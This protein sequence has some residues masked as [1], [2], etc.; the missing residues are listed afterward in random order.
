[1]TALDIFLSVSVATLM[2]GVELGDCVNGTDVSCV[3]GVAHFDAYRRHRIPSQAPQ[4][5]LPFLDQKSVFVARHPLSYSVNRLVLQHLLGYQ[6]YTGFVSL[7]LQDPALYDPAPLQSSDFPFVLSDV[8]I[9]ATSDWRFFHQAIYWDEETH[10]A[11]I[12]LLKTGSHL[13]LDPIEITRVLLDE[14]AR[15]KQQRGCLPTENTAQMDYSAYAEQYLS[16]D[17]QLQQVNAT[18][19]DATEDD[20]TSFCWIPVV[21]VAG[22]VNGPEFLDQIVS[23]NPHPPAAIVLA[24][25]SDALFLPQYTT[26]TLLGNTTWVCTARANPSTE[27]NL[28]TQIRLRVAN[29]SRAMTLEALELVEEPLSELPEEF[30]DDLYHSQIEQLN[31]MQQEIIANNPIDYFSPNNYQAWWAN[32]PWAMYSR[33]PCAGR[34]EPKFLS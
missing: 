16:V 2:S 18:E 23:Q 33:M 15:E 30:K 20:V 27:S 28:Y 6:F 31:Q 8:G 10:V 17:Q 11:L 5:V 1:M 29:H 9:P 21:W 4:M 25:N 3:T 26:P 12:S 19:D 34:P 14:I 22:F 7:A 32:A 24:P 13:H